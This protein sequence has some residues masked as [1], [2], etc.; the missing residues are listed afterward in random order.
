MDV[1]CIPTFVSLYLKEVSFS[2]AVPFLPFSN[3]GQFSQVWS[4]NSCKLFW[5]AQRVWCRRC[6]ILSTKESMTVFVC[7]C[8]CVYVCVC[9]CMCVCVCVYVCVCLCA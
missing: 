7:V 9:V 2:V 5:R 8:V 1:D 6:N 4:L 3:R